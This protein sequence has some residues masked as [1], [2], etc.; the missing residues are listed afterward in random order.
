[1][2]ALAGNPFQKKKELH[3]PSWLFGEDLRYTYFIWP[4]EEGSV[5]W[6][7]AIALLLPWTIGRPWWVDTSFEWPMLC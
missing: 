6:N 7:I 4:L 1:M 3:I 2:T 5:L